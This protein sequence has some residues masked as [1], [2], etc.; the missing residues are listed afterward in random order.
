MH[1]FTG[2]GEEIDEYV[3]RGFYIGITGFIC[4]ARRGAHI[5]NLLPRVPLDRL[6]I[7]TD[8]TS[9]ALCSCPCAFLPVVPVFALALALARCACVCDGDGCCVR[10]AVNLSPYVAPPAA[11]FM[12]PKGI[13]G[14]PARTRNEPAFLPHVCAAVAGT[15][16]GGHT[17]PLE[18]S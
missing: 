3:A 2:T 4:D 7:E 8:G 5:A 18:L 1:C 17:T 9:F 15:R 11:P 6:M 14:I 16:M 12:V 13:D 10:S